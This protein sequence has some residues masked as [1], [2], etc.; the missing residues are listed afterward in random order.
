M[1]AVLT[2]HP[3]TDTGEYDLNDPGTEAKYDFK[4]TDAIRR[5][6]ENKGRLFE[7]MTFHVTRSVEV[8][9]KVLRGA[10]VA[11]GGTVRLSDA[12]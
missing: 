2:P 3:A 1:L 12:L 4:L 8:D 10:I 11:H 9:H 6:G 5:A 7:G